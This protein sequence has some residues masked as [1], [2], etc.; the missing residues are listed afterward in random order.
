M[1]DS[2]IRKKHQYAALSALKDAVASSSFSGQ[3]DSERAHLLYQ[4][5]LTYSE[6]GDVIYY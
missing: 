5:A 4:L 6:Y 3:T 1:N 2:T